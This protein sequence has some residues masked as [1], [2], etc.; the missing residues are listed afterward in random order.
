MN[1]AVALV[2]LAAIGC[3]STSPK[4]AFDDTAKLVAD[5]SGQRIA[6]S[7]DDQGAPE[8]DRAVHDLLQQPLTVSAAVQIALLRNRRLQVRFEELGVAQADLV[9]AGLLKNPTLFGSIHLPITAS[10]EPDSTLIGAFDL[11]DAFSIPAKKHVAEAR[12]AATKA[13]IA[14]DVLDFSRDVAAAY[15]SAVGA[16]QALAMRRA[17]LESGQAATELAKR[18]AAAGNMSELDQANHENELEDLALAE[19]R[20][21]AHAAAAREELTRAMGLFGAETAFVL[22]EKLPELPADDAI[23]DHVESLAV[24]LR[25][26]LVA[27]H[28]DAQAVSHELALARNFRLLGLLGPVEVEHENTFTHSVV[29]GPGG[30]IEVP[31]FDQ[32]QAFIAR[33]EARKRQALDREYALAVDIRSEARSARER[34]AFERALVIQQSTRVVPARER[35]VALTQQRYNSMLSGVFQLIAA[36]QQEVIAYGELIESLRDYW[37]ARADLERGIGGRWRSAPDNH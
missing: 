11:I 3:A 10:T 35:V 24:S 2:A 33:L 13:Q 9:Q 18:L 22:P 16:A 19:L 30:S 8:I 6:W 23:P 7:E 37:I 5:R 17:V 21:Q 32:K 31:I 15:W 29:A 4:P 25:L 20:A 26:D 36:K 34:V 12:L 1:R 14:A 28:E 27:A